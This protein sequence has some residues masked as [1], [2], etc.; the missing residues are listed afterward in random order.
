MNIHR[1]NLK[2]EK[3]ENENCFYTLSGQLNIYFPCTLVVH[4]TK[5]WRIITASQ[6]G[7]HAKKSK[8]M[9]ISPL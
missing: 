4:M 9:N 5:V 7:F 1:K 8:F 6:K 2:S 3:S